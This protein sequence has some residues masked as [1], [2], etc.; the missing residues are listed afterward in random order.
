MYLRELNIVNSTR[1][2]VYRPY[3]ATNSCIELYIVYRATFKEM[4]RVINVEVSLAPGVVL[5]DLVKED[6]LN[7]IQTVYK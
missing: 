2:I 6:L 1:Y 3:K 4:Q 7:R 5:S